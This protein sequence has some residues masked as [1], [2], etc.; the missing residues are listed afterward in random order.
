M[1]NQEDQNNPVYSKEDM[2][3]FE[4]YEKDLADY[5]KQAKSFK[6]H[7]AS[8]Y[9]LYPAA[10]ATIGAAIPLAGAAAS[11]VSDIGTKA[12]DALNR[13]PTASAGQRWAEAV[14]GPG[15][16]TVDEAVKMRELEM[17]L[18]PG[19]R[20]LDGI[21]VDQATYDKVMA[22][23][24]AQKAAQNTGKTAAK[25]FHP[26]ELDMLQR[27]G[28]LRKVLGGAGAGFDLGEAYRRYKAGDTRGAVISGLGALGYP[29]SR[30][31]YPPAEVTGYGLMFGA[32]ALN[33]YLDSSKSE[34]NQV[35]KYALG[36]EIG[37]APSYS[38]SSFGTYTPMPAPTGITSPSWGATAP[39]PSTGFYTG[40][41]SGFSPATGMTPAD[42]L[43][44][45]ASMYGSG[46]PTP[47][48]VVMPSVGRPVMARPVT[49]PMFG[50]ALSPYASTTRPRFEEGGLA[51][52]KKAPSHFAKGGE[53]GVVAETLGAIQ[54]AIQEAKSMTPGYL[55]S[56]PT[57]PHPEVG[58]RYITEN[59]GNLAE[60]IPFDPAKYQG[61]S[62]V[63]VPWDSMTRNQAIKNISGVDLTKPFVTEGGFDYPRDISH[64]QQKIAGAS[65]EDIAKRIQKR[66]QIAQE[67]N[68]RNKGTGIVLGMPSTM[69]LG[70]ETFQTT[71]TG[72]TL[73]LLKQRELPKADIEQ[74]DQLVRNYKIPQKGNVLRNFVG[75]TDPR[76]EEQIMLGGH[77]LETT[78][79]E[80]RKGIM[81]RLSLKG[82]QEKL[83]YNVEDL[84]NAILDPTL[85]NLPKGYMGHTVFE[86]Y[87]SLELTPSKHSAF[88]TDFPGRYAASGISMPAEAI[89]PNQ[90]NKIYIELANKFPTFHPS[91]IRNM[92]LGALE[93]R[94]AGI[95]QMIN[96]QVI[97][98]YGKYMEGLKSGA[99]DPNNPIDIMDYLQS[100]KFA[101]GGEVGIGAEAL[102]AIE[103][104][105]KEAK[106]NAQLTQRSNTVPTYSKSG[107][108]LLNRG[109]EGPVIDFGS[110]LGLGSEELKK[111]F[112]EVHDYE[113]L[114]IQGYNPKFSKA[115][116]IPSD[117]Y[118]GLVNHSVLNV[119]PQDIRDEAMGDIGRVLQPGGT[120][121]ITA[122]TPA[123]VL[124][125]KG[126]YGGEP[127]SIITQ[128]TRGS[129]FQKGFSL[130]DLMDYAK[131][132][133]GK[134]FDIAPAPK[135]D[136][137]PLSGSA[138]MIQKKADGGPIEFT[139][140]YGTAVGTD[141]FGNKVLPQPTELDELRN[142]LPDRSTIQA[143]P[144]ATSILGNKL[145]EEA[146]R[147]WDKSG[148]R[149]IPDI[150]LNVASTITGIPSDMISAFS[151][152][153]GK[154]E[155]TNPL[156]GVGQEK[157]K[158][159][160][161]GSEQIHDFLRQKGITKEDYPLAENV[162]ML[163]APYAGR[164]PG[165]ISK[166]I[167]AT[168]GLPVGMSIKDVSPRFT[169]KNVQFTSPLEDALS[170]FPQKIENM[171]GD[172]W[173]AW[174]RNQ[175]ASV[176]KEAEA[177]NLSDV[178][179]T[180]ANVSK[181]DILNHV[182]ENSPKVYPKML[183]D[184]VW[185][186]EHA[187]GD[188]FITG[189][190]INPTERFADYNDALRASQK[191]GPQFGTEALTLPD[192]DRNYRELLIK[193]PEYQTTD[194]FSQAHFPEDKNVL[195]HLRMNDRTSAE[196]KRALFLEELQSDWGQKGRKLGFE[197]EPLPTNVS[198][199]ELTSQHYHKLDPDQKRWMNDY[200]DDMKSII[201]NTSHP[202][203]ERLY[204]NHLDKFQKWIES[205][206][207]KNYV[208]S[209]PYVKETKDWTNLGL[210]HAIKEAI[211]S[212]KD[213]VA[214]TTGAQQNFRNMKEAAPKGMI[215][216][217]DNIMP[218]T[219]NK[220]LKQLGV[221][222]RV[223]PIEFDL[224]DQ[225]PPQAFGDR[226][227]YFDPNEIIP[228]HRS[229]QWGFDIT[230]EL[231]QKILNEGLPKFKE[232][233]EVSKA[234]MRV[235]L[236]N[237]KKG[238]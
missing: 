33:Q 113:P 19:E 36:G 131:Y 215:D 63:M 7:E 67:E 91:H 186:E 188:F 121:I 179:N 139:N 84:Q 101:K 172:Q 146:K 208:P 211:E 164:V 5:N 6:E 23:R 76:L 8:G 210:K 46:A 59:L 197:R 190:H 226:P 111:L 217:Y 173:N 32:P 97:D 119:L 122:R 216:F 14:G 89:M 209:G 35:K 181:Q 142:M 66:F 26:E 65:G 143:I 195:A 95:S 125:A 205:Q 124:G 191:Y 166:G 178:L 128:G 55:K 52:L 47:S 64:I 110:G 184:D 29:L 108:I 151:P 115:S 75:F 167:K 85:K 13:K 158:P 43:A 118:Q 106:I 140:K 57:Q 135:A 165:M 51:K 174:L 214:W 41:R 39:A 232:G 200:N 15:G 154:G 227:E 129:T 137:G 18:K 103:D 58:S 224:K 116:D 235:E 206:S 148:P 9:D 192:G 11:K 105:I 70:A 24:A 50:G 77:G 12:I 28:L 153:L 42:Q 155:P 175:P 228:A 114:A 152:S 60:K 193:I 221:K 168:E 189:R 20:L 10:G 98:N 4:Q 223:R 196:G 230:P 2:A 27:T 31:P 109:V 199:E 83:G 236:A 171:P 180:K 144:K 30:I 61:A 93:K 56:T 177:S 202:D 49:R 149:S 222:E 136:Q 207:N 127:N 45:S 81:D 231:K 69:G 204:E 53:A 141:Q 198:P 72:I 212:N 182:N 170:N 159:N 220:L 3:A 185:V 48:P 150:A 176:K 107:N 22:E 94:N 133:L 90:F 123:A 134:K 157:E 68:L 160:L 87:P 73:D 238:Y 234:Q 17:G 1:A 54:D 145:A 229:K 169:S 100:P 117:A 183:N 126:I 233:S 138:I 62:V 25:S 96:N 21:V 92:T 44:L 120:G 218:Q 74:L 194:K 187:D 82:S 225:L 71:P 163:A 88:N 213:Q 104:A 40:Y 102:S 201:S 86:A 156:L 237:N 112:P 79:P 37:A 38:T 132:R 147:E 78:A 130:Q 219:A 203:Q 34:G 162:A 16:K 161:L 80:L 99:F